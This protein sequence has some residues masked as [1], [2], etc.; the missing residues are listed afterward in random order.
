MALVLQGA[1]RLHAACAAQF[2]SVLSKDIIMAEETGIEK[3]A[4]KERA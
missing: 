4:S 1:R 3:G 2:A